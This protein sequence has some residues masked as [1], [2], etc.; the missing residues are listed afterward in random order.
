MPAR[1]RPSR[2]RR[3]V[4]W[5]GALLALST[6]SPAAQAFERQWHLGGGLGLGGFGKV[7][8]SSVPLSGEGLKLPMVGAHAGY[9]ISDVF[10][11]RLE[12]TWGLHSLDGSPE[13]V[14]PELEQT[15]VVSA[16]TG[17]AYKLDVIEWIPYLGLLVGYYGYC[18]GPALG[19]DGLEPGGGSD[20]GA[21]LILGLD[22]AL[23]RD[24]A[25]GVQLRYH[26]LLAGEDY[27]TAQLRVEHTWGF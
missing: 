19:S 15:H 3:G 21:S 5:V 10:D 27:F 13:V 20:L 26:R 7:E 17:L 25:V 22:H 14:D 4:A 6:A 24:V 8:G 1:S 12:L 23:S 9:G 2:S 18:G 11:V 16:A